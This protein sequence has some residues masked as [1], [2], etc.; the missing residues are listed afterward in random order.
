MKIM[1][2]AL[3]VVMQLTPGQRY[4]VAGIIAGETIPG[5]ETAHNIIACTI[6]YD[7]GRGY[8]TNTLPNRWYGWRRPGQEHFD[9]WDRAV[10]GMCEHYPICR[11]L[12]NRQDFDLHWQWIEAPTV[13]IKDGRFEVVCVVEER[14]EPEEIKCLRDRPQIR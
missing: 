12:G 8:T 5:N 14:E 11:F 7:L 1:A 4:Q 13:H 3:A 2:M 6:L 9:A 10:D